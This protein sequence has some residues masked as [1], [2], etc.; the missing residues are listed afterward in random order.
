VA[1]LYK[2]SNFVSGHWQ[3]GGSGVAHSLL[4]VKFERKGCNGLRELLTPTQVGI[5]F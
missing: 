4:E 2:L 5:Q 1:F 3:N